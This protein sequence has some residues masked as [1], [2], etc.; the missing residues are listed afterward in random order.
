LRHRAGQADSTAPYGLQCHG[1]EED[2]IALVAIGWLL[3]I[4]AIVL[5]FSIYFSQNME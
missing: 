4:W 5:L 2:V 3:A 1:W